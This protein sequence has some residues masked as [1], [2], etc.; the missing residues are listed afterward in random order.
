[1]TAATTVDGRGNLHD[2]VGQFAGKRP[3]SKPR[4]T[5]AGVRP[6][7]FD[8]A[9]PSPAPEFPVHPTPIEPASPSAQAAAL[10]DGIVA[11]AQAH[12][13]AIRGDLMSACSASGAVYANLGADLMSPAALARDIDRAAADKRVTPGRAASSIEHAIRGIVVLPTASYDDG[14][15]TIIDSLSNRG[16]RIVSDPGPVWRL[17]G[18]GR[19]IIAEAPSGQRFEIQLHTAAS[20]GASSATAVGY[21]ELRNPATPPPRR[22][23]LVAAMT[24]YFA[25]HVRV[26]PGVSVR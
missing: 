15:R 18:A 2:P 19:T 26:P 10:A 12:L 22:A 17:G 9:W 25:R 20:L 21:A 8:D 6:S 3:N 16:H 13:P 1:M 7:L 14:A 11:R 23:E 24:D 5:L 4:R